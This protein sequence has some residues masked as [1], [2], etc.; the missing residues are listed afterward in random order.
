[1][2]GVR[3]GSIRRRTNQLI[4]VLAVYASVSSPP[5][6][7]LGLGGTSSEVDE[8]FPRSPPAGP[9]DGVSI[10][11]L[12]SLKMGESIFSQSLWLINTDRG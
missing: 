6:P 3:A 8:L 5:T 9:G 11:E 4:G 10:L 12:E 1:M 7:S 2:A